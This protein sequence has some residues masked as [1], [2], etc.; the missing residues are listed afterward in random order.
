MT[1][2]VERLEVLVGDIRFAR[3][4]ILGTEADAQLM[5]DGDT[6]AE[7]CAEITRLRSELEAAKKDA[8]R[9]RWLRVRNTFD[10]DAIFTAMRCTE[11]GGMFSHNVLLCDDSLDAAIDAEMAKE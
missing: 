11:Q 6:V 3:A 4:E 1:D 8:G 5:A 7:A 2:I 9:Y 10:G